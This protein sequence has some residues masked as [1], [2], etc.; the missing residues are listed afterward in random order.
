MSM[1]A[2][3]C[4]GTKSSS[5]PKAVAAPLPPRSV[6]VISV[7][8]SDQLCPIIAAIAASTIATT[9][10][11]GMILAAISIA[12]IPL[13][14]SKNQT[15]TPQPMPPVARMTLVAPMLPL[16]ISKILTLRSRPTR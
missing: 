9:V 13:V 11:S 6:P 5:V 2:I 3:S 1:A 15:S 12:N 8:K 7:A 4:S 10:F 14:L 16:P